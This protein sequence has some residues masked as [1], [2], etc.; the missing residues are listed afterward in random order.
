M[1]I[2]LIKQLLKQSQTDDPRWRAT[3]PT[4]CEVCEENE[5]LV[6][7]RPTGYEVCEK[8]DEVLP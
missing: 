8:C 7:N 4:P 5:A 6:T 3:S 2:K 1:I